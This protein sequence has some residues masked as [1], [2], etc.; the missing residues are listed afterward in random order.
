MSMQ[1]WKF[2]LKISTVVAGVIVFGQ[3]AGAFVI[4]GP[5]HAPVSFKY[6]NFDVGNLYDTTP[7]GVTGASGGPGAGLGDTAG[8]QA[9][10]TGI[11]NQGIPDPT[12]T[13]WDA[14]GIANITVI[15]KY[16][17]D[18]SGVGWHTVWSNGD[19]GIELDGFL[20]G[21]QDF[22]VYN[23]S[24]GGTQV[25]GSSGFVA[26]FYVNPVGTY[27]SH[28]VLDN[29]QGGNPGDI[30]G[31]GTITANEYNYVVNGI[32]SGSKWLEVAGEPGNVD[33]PGTLGG[34]DVTYQTTVTNVIT[35]EGSGIGYLS[36]VPGWGDPTA[37]AMLNTNTF[38]PLWGGAQA[39]DLRLKVTNSP[40]PLLP[41]GDSSGWLITSND[42]VS[43]FA[44]PEP[45]SALSLLLL[46][47]LGFVR[48]RRRS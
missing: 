3:T 37:E 19:G 23:D 36:V 45:A 4:P 28:S 25:I 1:V 30:A 41:N 12:G 7:S 5:V 15:Q 43:G 46:A 24:V 47:G 8:N 16:F 44:V 9:A 26:D 29:G 34:Y 17:D 48:R 6:Q 27:G 42:P 11:L 14:Y 40:A 39:A 2:T 20:H 31:D 38:A 10:V 18:G 22:S 21:T 33:G 13:G 35:G 32:T